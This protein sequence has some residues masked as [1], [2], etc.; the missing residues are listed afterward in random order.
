M[1]RGWR[2]QFLRQWLETEMRRRLAEYGL[3]ETAFRSVCVE[4]TI[5]DELTALSP[6]PLLRRLSE[7]GAIGEVSE[8]LS[9]LADA[10]EADIVMYLPQNIEVKAGEV[11]EGPDLRTVGV[12][13]RA[14]EFPK[15]VTV[16]AVGNRARVISRHMK[17]SRTVFGTVVE[18]GQHDDWLV[19][20]VSRGRKGILDGSR[21]LASTIVV[22]FDEEDS[23]S[24]EFDKIRAFLRGQ[25]GAGAVSIL[26]PALPAKHP[27]RI[28][29]SNG[30]L[31]RLGGECH[32]ILDSAI[33]RS[34][35]WW[36]SSK[37]SFDRRI[38]DVVALAVA[39]CGSAGLREELQKRRARSSP[40]ILSVGLVPKIDLDP[41][42]HLEPHAIRLGSEATW[43]ASDPDRGDSAILFS[44]RINAD[45]VGLHD[46]DKQVMDKQV[47]VEGRLN[48]G[49][50]GDFAGAVVAHVLGGRQRGKAAP[51]WRVV[52][53]PSVPDRLVQGLAF[54]RHCRGF[55]IRGDGTEETNLAV[56]GEAPTVAVVAEANSVGWRVARYTDVVSIRRFSDDSGPY[57]V[58]PDEI[59]METIRSSEINRQLATRG[60]DQRDVFRISDNLLREWLSSPSVG[61]RRPAREA[62]RPMRSATR[63]HGELDSDYL[64][65]REYV[66]R[67]DDPAARELAGLLQRERGAS[68]D[69]R[70]LK[71]GADLRR[72]WTTP[73]D[74][75]R[76]YALVDGAIPVIV[77][78]LEG[79][80]VPV[81]DLFVVDGDE[82]VPALFRSRVFRIWAGATLPSASSWM[83]RFSVTATFGGFPIVE[84]FRIVGQEGS[85]AALIAE[86]APGRLNALSSEIGRQIDR[87]L[88]RLP[89]KGWR[90]AHELGAKGRAMDQLNEMILEWYGLPRDAG[91]IAVLKRLQEMNATLD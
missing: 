80:E 50:F 83:A 86:R 8:R 4:E 72:C 85:F 60:V 70:P 76:R 16:I 12:T 28:L 31:P 55:R 17:R 54:P 57:E 91:D 38:A 14:D 53:E 19:V 59:D 67:K 23:K 63:P 11:L 21:P 90:A 37:R 47:M 61:G 78:E 10:L 29:D 3:E 25:A 51:N 89:S 64:L 62:A 77:V 87:Q 65:M 48:R 13:A 79:N 84:P 45:V 56:V 22:L 5:P 36:G 75:F 49:R 1:A 20:P 44:L 24:A 88:A 2:R 27:S 40:L 34:P 52:E 18:S 30:H 66:L 43:V 68:L 71:R 74:G 39:A 81:E 69:A 9:G 15:E 41:P 6:D 42:G 33:A 46:V 35:F 7:I 32:A 73:S 82:S 58:L 26:V